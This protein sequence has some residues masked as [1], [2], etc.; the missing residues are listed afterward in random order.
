LCLKP[1]WA[2][3]EKAAVVEQRQA[4]WV[5]RDTSSPSAF[6]PAVREHLQNVI[7]SKYGRITKVGKDL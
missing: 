1:S 6:L 4:R 7:E 5:S 3:G 2:A